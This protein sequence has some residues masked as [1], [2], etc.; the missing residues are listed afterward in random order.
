MGATVIRGRDLDGMSVISLICRDGEREAM[1]DRAETLL[2][3][4]IPNLEL[5]GRAI[6]V[7][8]TDFLWTV[9]GLQREVPEGKAN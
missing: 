9:R 2:A 5:H 7:E 8:R 3:S 4:S 6:N 1:P